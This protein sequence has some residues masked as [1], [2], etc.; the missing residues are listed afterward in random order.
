MEQNINLTKTPVVSNQRR[1]VILL[2]LCQA[3][4]MTATSAI[5]TASALV[6]YNIA[7]DKALS[8]LPLAMQFIAVMIVTAPASYLMK[9]IGRRNGI[10]VGL[11]IGIVGSALATVAIYEANFKLFCIACLHCILALP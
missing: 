4:F 3:L 8:T 10:I 9:I 1:N 7:D 2:A 5:V 6:G 11:I